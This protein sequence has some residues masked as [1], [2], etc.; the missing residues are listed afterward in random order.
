MRFVC[1]GFRL[2][3]LKCFSEAYE[4]CSPM[5]GSVWQCI[6]I[7]QGVRVCV[8]SGT[9]SFTHGFTDGPLLSPKA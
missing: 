4:N 2:N 3:L 8:M 9:W 7:S 6:I 5:A 1:F